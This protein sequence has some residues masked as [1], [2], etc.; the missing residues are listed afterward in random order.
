MKLVRQTFSGRVSAT[1]DGALPTES[2]LAQ[3]KRQRLPV[4]VLSMPPRV[5]SID[6][7]LP[8]AES[9]EWLTV[10]TME[11][12]NPRAVEDMPNLVELDLWV[13]S[14]HEINFRQLVSLKIFAGGLGRG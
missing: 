12:R 3:I 7:L 5:S 11:C 2:D 6:F 9:I 14:A 4:H 1:I 10:T 13:D 8:I